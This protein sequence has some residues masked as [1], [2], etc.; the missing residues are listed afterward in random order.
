VFVHLRVLLAFFGA[1]A[2]CLEARL[3]L[4]LR[5]C[6]VMLGLTHEQSARGAADVGAVEI[7]PD[8]LA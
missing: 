4:P 8:A 1:G 5:G 3:E 7:Q 2:A 6:G